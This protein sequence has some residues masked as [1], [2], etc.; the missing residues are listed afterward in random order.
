MPTHYRTP[1]LLWLVALQLFYWLGRL[2]IKTGRGEMSD[3]P[4]V[5]ALTD[6]GSRVLIAGMVATTLAAY[7]LRLG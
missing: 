1:S 3:D 5:Y 7:F 2:W 4:L 6:F